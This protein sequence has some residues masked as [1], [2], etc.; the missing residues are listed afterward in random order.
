MNIKIIILHNIR[1][2]QV[3]IGLH[4]K[5]QNTQRGQ[6]TESTGSLDIALSRDVKIKK[7]IK[8]KNCREPQVKS[9]NSRQS[10]RNFQLL[11]KF[12]TPLVYPGHRTVKRYVMVFFH[13]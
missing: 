9:Q 4:R 6:L 7:K 13:Y 8:P 12:L 10:E 1:K 11:T 5:L 3:I 2:L